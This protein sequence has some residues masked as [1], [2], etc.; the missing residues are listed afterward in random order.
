M[1]P[2]ISGILPVAPTGGGGTFAFGSGFFFGFQQDCFGQPQ[3]NIPQINGLPAGQGAPFFALGD[4]R[5]V[6]G[7]AGQPIVSNA[8]G[9]IS[10]FLMTATVTQGPRQIPLVFE[11]IPAA[12][13]LNNGVMDII[14]WSANC[15][16]QTHASLGGGQPEAGDP[17]LVNANTINLLPHINASNSQTI[18]PIY[19]QWVIGGPTGLAANQAVLCT[20]SFTIKDSG[21]NTATTTKTFVMK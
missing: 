10:E 20:L 3:A 18:E 13:P 14:I 12:V 19:I 15:D 8:T 7:I 6:V 1:F 9:N 17:I 4:D 5:L 16:P 21:N 11:H 2:I